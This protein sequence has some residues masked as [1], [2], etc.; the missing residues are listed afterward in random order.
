MKSLSNSIVAISG[1]DGT[2]PQGAGFLIGTRLVLTCAHVVNAALGRSLG[3]AKRPTS[4]QKVAVLFCALP[5][6]Q[7]PLIAAVAEE[8]D[9]WKPFSPD[10]RPDADFCLLKVEGNPPPSATKVTL[11]QS[12][13]LVSRS[14][15]AAGFPE[16]WDFDIS[17][18]AIV[19]EYQGRFLLRPDPQ[20]TPS[21]LT[22]RR[23]LVGTDPR[24]AGVIYH[25]FSGAPVEVDGTV[26]GMIVEARQLIPDATA[27]MMPSTVFPKRLIR[28]A[29][30]ISPD[31]AIATRPA[32]PGS[33]NAVLVTN[34]LEQ[35]AADIGLG[36]LFINRKVVREPKAGEP[37]PS[38]E[39]V[40]PPDEALGDAI[41][42]ANKLVLLGTPGLGK[43]TVLKHFET[44]T[45][46]QVLQDI[47][48][49]ERFT[50]PVL[51]ELKNYRGEAE[52]ESLLAERVNV[53]L[54][55]TQTSLSMDGQQSLRIMK[56]W[57]ADPTFRFVI[58]LDA[59][60]EVP[61]A[62]HEQARSLMI[63]LLNYPHSFVISC[64]TTDYDQT[65]RDHTEA[66][67][68]VPLRKDE[69]RG[70]L[71]QALGTK[72]NELLKELTRNAELLSLASNALF[73]SMI[74]EMARRDMKTPRNRG[75]LFK[76]FVKAMIDRRRRSGWRLAVA[77]DIVL[78][79]TAALGFEM[80]DRS[81]TTPLLGVV[82]KWP[83]PVETETLD[84]I[85]GEAK[86]FR[87]L[88]SDGSAADPVEFIHPLWGEYFAAEHLNA[89]LTGD[90]PDFETVLGKRIETRHWR[91]VMI[92]LVG[93][94]QQPV[95]FV[96]WFAARLTREAETGHLFR[97]GSKILFFV[98]S[99]PSQVDLLMECWDGTT[100]ST[101]N[102]SREVII[103]LLRTV[104]Q[105]TGPFLI[106]RRP[107]LFL[108]TRPFETTEFRASLEAA[109]R[110]CAVE[111]LPDI[112][113]FLEYEGKVPESQKGQFLNFLFKRFRRDEFDE[114]RE[115]AARLRSKV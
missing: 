94:L 57:L 30:T 13:N 78:S 46:A 2:E 114:A 47:T 42:R 12:Q 44:Q 97:R 87:F 96:R 23:A 21:L 60:D 40:E 58:L 71:K 85:L 93:L 104:I 101:S 54:R 61:E 99:P 91:E 98:F 32:E 45:A 36:Q 103:G 73:L 92:A 62:H 4:A 56:A 8:S 70:Y 37:P 65:L 10:A 14:F 59:M 83:I 75:L 107:S 53:V 89:Q 51:I 48:S 79:A 66:C 74:A 84:A 27:Y 110:L 6:D 20:K 16:D 105:K 55:P 52:I 18:G 64:R 109:E 31:Q 38:D 39:T 63:A 86:R 41:E 95:Q 25:G 90:D 100:A 111:V 33:P 11:G 17:H 113:L 34:Y 106:L 76:E 29:R 115:V 5:G 102:E 82:R 68:L 19:G 50:I 88:V 67:E 35:L 108:D 9:A 69:I 77:P 81:I 80:T 49:Q 1:L 28:R 3:E 24:P 43:S 15:Q 7:T 72:A 26:V 112:E 22:R